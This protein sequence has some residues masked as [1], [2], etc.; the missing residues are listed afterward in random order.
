MGQKNFSLVAGLFFLLVAVLHALRLALG[1]QATVDGWNLPLWVSWVGL[2][3]A[4]YL[5]FE[6]LRLSTRR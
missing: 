5:A 4:G 3:I 2:A 6:G 1:W